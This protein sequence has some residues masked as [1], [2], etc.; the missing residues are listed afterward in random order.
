MTVQRK[1]ISISCKACIATVLRIS[2]GV[3]ASAAAIGTSLADGL[4]IS[5]VAANYRAAN[6]RLRARGWVEIVNRSDKPVDLGSY[7]LRAWGVNRRGRV[8]DAPLTFALL[9]KAV[10]PGGYHVLA[11]KLIDALK[12]ADKSSYI[13]SDD[14]AYF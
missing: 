4:Y 5:G 13:V 12:G 7:K 14:G 10:A 2:L 9:Q 1:F 6:D 11:A 3:A 8:S